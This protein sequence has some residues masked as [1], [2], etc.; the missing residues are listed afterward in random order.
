MYR[1]PDT[2]IKAFNDHLSSIISKTQTEKKLL[3]ILADFNINLLNAD[4]HGATHDFLDIMYSN[5]LL[6][7]I[8]KPTRVIKRSSPL[9]DNIF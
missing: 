9:V 3:Y 2:D 1:P 6:P 8:N 7:N 4:S 5:S